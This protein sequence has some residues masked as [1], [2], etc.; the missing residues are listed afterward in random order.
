MA[1]KDVASDAQ[2]KMLGMQSE[3]TVK[4]QF[5]PFSKPTVDIEIIIL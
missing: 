4:R 1:S 2:S 3:G 5:W